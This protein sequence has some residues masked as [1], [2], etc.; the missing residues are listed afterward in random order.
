MENSERDENTRPPNLL[1]GRKVMTSLDIVLNSRDITLPI[2][3]H[4]VK[5]MVFPMI[6]YGYA[7]PSSP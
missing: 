6:T 4:T 1:L 7:R 3:V 5:A 2:K